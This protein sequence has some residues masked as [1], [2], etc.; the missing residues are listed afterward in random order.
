M[1]NWQCI[2]LVGAFAVNVVVLCKICKKTGFWGACCERAGFACVRARAC[3]CWRLPRTHCLYR[4]RERCVCGRKCRACGRLCV[5]AWCVCGSV[6]CRCHG[7]PIHDLCAA[8]ACKR[9]G[10]LWLETRRRCA[11]IDAPVS[12][13]YSLSSLSLSLSLSRSLSL[14]LSLLSHSLSLLSLSL[15]RS[16]DR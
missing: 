11:Y 1:A 15:A 3:V 9:S 13:V 12:V 4:P 5:C 10:R 8:R 14:S 7:G 6:R 2:L 16:I